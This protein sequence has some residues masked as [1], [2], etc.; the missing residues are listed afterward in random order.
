MAKGHFSLIKFYER[1]I[2]RIFP[3]LILVIL[4]CIFI[5]WFVQTANEFEKLGKH[6]IANAVF[7]SNFLLWTES[8]YFDTASETKPLLHLW[9]LAVEE[10]FYVV[11]PA[12][13]LIIWKFKLSTTLFIS[14]FTI[15]SL[16]LTYSVAGGNDL[17]NGAFY[18][19]VT[20]AW[21]L[22]MG[23]LLAHFY[24]NES[25]YLKNLATKINYFLKKIFS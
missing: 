4:S 17:S 8:G 2:V 24:I 6:V 3:A 23:A 21:E 15:T 12:I 9:S 1:R 25:I 18:L 13:I 19:P 20:R 14:I 7:V 5:G 22:C 10:Q 16:I 11:W